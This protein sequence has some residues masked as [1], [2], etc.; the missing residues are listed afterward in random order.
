MKISS[1]KRFNFEGVSLHLFGII[2]KMDTFR[3]GL[4]TF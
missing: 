2:V 4:D 1:F 3:H